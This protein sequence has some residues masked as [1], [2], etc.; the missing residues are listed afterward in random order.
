MI[1]LVHNHRRSMALGLSLLLPMLAGEV[2]AAT[3]NNGEKSAQTIVV[4]E[5]TTKREL[6]VAPGES[7]EFCASGCF[8]TLPNGDREA[9]TGSEELTLSGGSVSIK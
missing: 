1:K 6:V 9:L 2:L 7:A 5:G 3:I 4:T 8:V